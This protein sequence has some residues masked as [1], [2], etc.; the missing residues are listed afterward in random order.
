M[1]EDATLTTRRATQLKLA[2]LGR[3]TA[4]IAHEVRNP[5]GAISHAAQLL[6]ESPHT[7]T[8]NDTLIKIISKNSWRVN[9]IVEN[10]LQLSRN[11]PPNT[12][13]FDLAIWLR[14]YTDEF[15]QQHSLI[16]SDIKLK[17]QDKPLFVTF[18]QGQ[19]FQVVNNL[20]ENGLRYSK[21]KPL[22]KLTIGMDS[23]R[24]YLDIQDCG[25]GM[26]DKTK[27]QIFE[28]FFTTEPKGNGLGLYLSREIC[29]A[30]QA[31]L[32]LFSNTNRGCCFRISFPK[33][34]EN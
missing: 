14:S 34:I 27:N 21:D 18:D 30:N 1:L 4:S 33:V 19:I 15:I 16:K 22:L 13:N 3:L 31:S 20:C 10:I 11:K 5:L 28:P 6:E 2:S 23:N 29:E 26:T 17:N 7:S 12:E 32:N 25:Q 24:P 8:N 9:K